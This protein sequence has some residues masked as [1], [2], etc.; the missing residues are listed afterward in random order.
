MKFSKSFALSLVCAAILSGCGGDDGKDGTNGAQGDAGKDGVS[1]FVTT[2][3]V[4]NTNAQ[5]AYAVYSDSLLAAKALKAQL[6]VFV[7]APTNENFTKA[8]EAWL[9]AREPYG[10]SEVYRFREG[11]IDNLTKN[12][13]GDWILEPEAGPEGAI[14][15]W[16]LAEAFIDYTIDMDG[17]QNPESIASISVGGNIIS[18]LEEFPVINKEVLKS[19]F[20]GLNEAQDEANVTSGYHAIE[21]LLWGQDLNEDGTYTANRDYSAGYRKASDYYTVENDFEGKVGT[22]TSGEAGSDNALCIR[23]GQYLIAAAD[24]LID[25]LQ[26]VTNAWAPGSGFHY[27]EFTKAENAKTSLAKIL[28]GMGRLSYGE[29]AGERM[30]IALRTDS[31]EDEH[32]CFSDNT[33]R[34]IYLDAK[35]IQNAFLGSYTRDT[36]ENLQGA[37]I[38]D[39]LVVEG[40]PEL[41]NKLRSALEL[42][43]AKAAVIDTNAK[44]GTSFDLQIQL[45]EFKPAVTETIKALQFQTDV[46][47]EAITALEVTTS[48]LKQDTEEFGG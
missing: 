25:D 47:N 22:C 36:G 31:Q 41:A 38:Y 28:E 12:D 24:L 44:M 35:G 23:R 26:A 45:N 11:P 40:H 10:E 30:S 9:D 13:A 34:D 6:E 19:S 48:D 16:P 43:M 5:H 37:S 27:N 7:A 3:D 21:F 8:K 14:N 18:N 46:I 39:L 4:V 33:H 1:V 29:L 17:A 32:S 20:G 15:A 42:T 2:S